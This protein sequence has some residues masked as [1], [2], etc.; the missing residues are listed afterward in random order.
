MMRRGVKSIKLGGF[1]AVNEGR[2]GNCYSLAAMPNTKFQ[3]GFC[4]RNSGTISSCFLRNLRKNKKGYNFFYENSGTILNGFADKVGGK[5]SDK[6]ENDTDSGVVFCSFKDTTV[7]DLEGEYGYEANDFWV[8]NEESDSLLSLELKKKYYE[9]SQVVEVEDIKPI[10]IN[11]AKELIDISVKINSGDQE[12]AKAYYV[13]ADDINLKGKKWIPMGSATYPFRGI[14]DGQGHKIFNFKVA[15]K[16]IAFAGFFGVI[17]DAVVLNLQVDG[18]VRAGNYTAG[19]VGMNKNGKIYSCSAVAQLI[20]KNHVGGFVGH[21]TGVIEGCFYSGK[22]KKIFLPVIILL[23]GIS[24]AGL[25]GLMSLYIL[26]PMKNTTTFNNVPVDPYAAK[27]SSE[28]IYTGEGNKASFSFS[29]VIEFNGTQANFNLSNPDTTNQ[30]MTIK[31]QITDQELVNK[32]GKTGRTEAEQKSLDS[33]NYDPSN[34]R[35]TISESGLIKPGYSLNKLIL[36]KLPDGTYLQKGVYNGIGYLSFF[37]HETNE[38]SIV[39]S[40]VPVAIVIQD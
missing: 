31:I 16:D 40:Q 33:K 4:F 20:G 23:S 19:F 37:N 39:N 3:G 22:I 12:A 24:T 9:V 8:K 30:S 14:F 5:E 28:K 32:T 35:I 21:N 15:K 1:C 13:L 2:I 26:N 18:I 38:K 29:D 11:S 17:E 36:K 34:T 25:V 27:T 7:S 10:I 6:S